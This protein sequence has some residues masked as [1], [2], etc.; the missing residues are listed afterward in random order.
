MMTTKMAIG[1][2]TALAEMGKLAERRQKT[3]DD[4]EGRINKANKKGAM[5]NDC[6]NWLLYPNINKL[7]K[8]K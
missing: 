3:M 5:S 1:L 2:G 8:K 6:K 4:L 7:P